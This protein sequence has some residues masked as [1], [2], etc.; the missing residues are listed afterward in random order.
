VLAE[1][2]PE[3]LRLPQQADL[4]PMSRDQIAAHLEK[5]FDFADVRRRQHWQVRAPI[6]IEEVEDVVPRRVH[7]G[8]ERRPRHRR[9]RRIRRLQAPVGSGFRQLREVGQQAV[10]HEAVG[11]LR[12]LSVEPDDDQPLD[13]GA[14][15][16]PAGDRTEQGAER[17]GQ[18]RRDRDQNRREDDEERRENRE[19]GAGPDVRVGASRREQKCDCRQQK[20]A[21]EDGFDGTPPTNWHEDIVR[22]VVY[23]TP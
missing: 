12:I 5:L 20:R 15:R 23:T 8:A 9:N 1:N 11:E 3:R 13:C 22:V 19:A 4:R 10:L 16:P 17:P 6:A 21:P 2:R 18:N 7:A 14:R